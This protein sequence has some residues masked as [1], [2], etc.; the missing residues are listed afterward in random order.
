VMGAEDTSER[1]NYKI[2][3]YALA[4]HEDQS[5]PLRQHRNRREHQVLRL[6]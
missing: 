1:L 2:A 3:E 5:R 4:A 6:A